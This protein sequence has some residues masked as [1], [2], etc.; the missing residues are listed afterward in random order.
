VVLPG[1]NEALDARNRPL[2]ASQ[3]ALLAE[4][5]DAAARILELAH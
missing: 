4:A 1:V 5:L 3:L 2:A